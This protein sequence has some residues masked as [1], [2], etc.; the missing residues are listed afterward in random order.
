MKYASDLNDNQWMKIQPILKEIGCRNTMLKREQINAV[1]Y[2]LDTGCKWR[3]LPQDF[4]NWKTV[5]SFYR[6]C[7]LKGNWSRIWKQLSFPDG[8]PVR[9]GNTGENQSYAMNLHLQ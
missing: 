1:L 5:Y 3:D 6:R 4:P 9:T 8:V 7:C 2:L